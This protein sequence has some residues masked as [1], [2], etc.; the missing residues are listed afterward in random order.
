MIVAQPPITPVASLATRELVTL[1]PGVVKSIEAPR[2]R[3]SAPLTARVAPEPTCQSC[4]T[5][6]RV[7]GVLMVVVPL[8]KVLA[9]IPPPKVS[10]PEPASV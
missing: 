2:L 6:G 4:S 7:S 10:G 9:L 5:A 8:L 3:V 1:T